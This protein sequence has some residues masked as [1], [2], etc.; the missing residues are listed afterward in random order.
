MRGIYFANYLCFVASQLG[1]ALDVMTSRSRIV[2][3]AALVASLP[4]ATAVTDDQGQ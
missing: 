3:N 4:N 1:K 2:V